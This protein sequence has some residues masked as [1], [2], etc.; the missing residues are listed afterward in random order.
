MRLRDVSL[1]ALLVSTV[2]EKDDLIP[3]LTKIDAIAFPL[4]DAQFT[5][6][7]TDWFDV[8]EM[9]ELQTLQPSGN[10]LLCTL[11]T[12]AVQPSGQCVCL[13]DYEHALM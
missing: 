11:V 9:P 12:Q 7:M 13:P 3:L 6:P 10:L 1:L 5:H 8:A 4:M 2:Q